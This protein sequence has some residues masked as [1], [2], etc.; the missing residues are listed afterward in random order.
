MGCLSLL[1]TNVE[2]MGALAERH[3]Y[4]DAGESL[5]VIDPR[6]AFVFH[7]LPR[8]FVVHYPHRESAARANWED[9]RDKKDRLFHDF[10]SERMKN[11]S[12][13]TRMCANRPK[14]MT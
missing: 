4:N 9:W 14:P 2:L 6:E 12:I 1:F 5:M 10:I 3:G 11:A 8:A 13:R 7:V